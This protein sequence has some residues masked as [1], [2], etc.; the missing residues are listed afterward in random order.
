MA[1]SPSAF[2]TPSCDC[3][4]RSRR[5]CR[6]PSRR[7]GPR[8]DRPILSRIEGQIDFQ[9]LQSFDSL[10]TQLTS[11]LEEAYSPDST[12]SFVSHDNASSVTS[13]T[14]DLEEQRHTSPPF[15]ATPASSDASFGY[16]PPQ[17]F[18]PRRQDRFT[19]PSYPHHS[20][21]WPTYGR[22]SQS[23]TSNH[24]GPPSVTDCFL[25]S[26]ISPVLQPAHLLAGIDRISQSDEAARLARQRLEFVSPQGP[27]PTQHQQYPKI[28]DPWNTQRLRHEDLMV[29]DHQRPQP[30]PLD[31]ALSP[32]SSNE[33]GSRRNGPLS[34][35][36]RKNANIVRQMGACRRC[37]YMK[38]P[39]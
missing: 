23:C 17:Y 29:L 32:T 34:A 9:S 3:L 10:D 27:S 25:V 12:Y 5:A 39:V 11:S 13:T 6:C 33:R 22:G 24:S 31:T 4:S 2:R 21:T 19:P 8:K 18:D 28:H 7:R 30:P 36:A 1:R 37:V 20:W 15:V 35:E 16:P 26:P 38:E 14:A